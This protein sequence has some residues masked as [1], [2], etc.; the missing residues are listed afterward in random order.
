LIKGKAK[1]ITLKLR[2]MTEKRNI[3]ETYRKLKR[4]TYR[5]R[6]NK[7]EKHVNINETRIV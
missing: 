2:Y 1:D 7:N 5:M 4:K 6:G 3:S